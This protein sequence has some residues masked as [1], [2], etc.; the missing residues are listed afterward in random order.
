MMAKTTNQENC[1]QDEQTCL[2]SEL[3]SDSC[4]F[5]DPKDINSKAESCA[6]VIVTYANSKKEEINP[7]RCRDSLIEQACEEATD[8]CSTAI[9]N[10][11]AEAPPLPLE[12]KEEK[13][14]DTEIK[15]ACE[16]ANAGKPE[17]VRNELVNECISGVNKFLDEQN[18]TED[19]PTPDAGDNPTPDAGN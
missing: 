1:N 15:T 9:N 4:E 2:L 14:T 18:K 6:E 19:N 13:C 3:G 10:H 17:E 5:T 12:C 7:E 8:G 11:I 16:E